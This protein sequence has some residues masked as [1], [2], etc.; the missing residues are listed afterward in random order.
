MEHRSGSQIP[1]SF[2][3]LC[4]LC[5]RTLALPPLESSSAMRNTRHSDGIFTSEYSK[6]LGQIFARKYLESIVGKRVNNCP[7]EESM[8]VKRH[9]DG[10]FTNDY[11]RLRKQIAAQKYL[12][13]VLAGKRSSQKELNTDN[14]PD[15]TELL[16]PVFSEIYDD[17]P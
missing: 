9:S 7:I 3:L 16:D 17:L 11:S 5:S 2:I 13:S 14:L 6:L 8:P 12:N 15:E 4:I 10:V 1:L